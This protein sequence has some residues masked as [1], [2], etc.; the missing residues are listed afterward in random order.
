MIV[1]PPLVAEFDLAEYVG[2][3]LS[4]NQIAYLAG[5]LFLALFGLSALRHASRATGVLPAVWV[6]VAI[7]LFA[8]AL[9]LAARSFPD[10][11]PDWLRPWTETDRLTRAAAVAVL[12][13]C[14]AVLL[15]AY[16]VRGSMSRLACRMAGLGLAGVAVWLAGGWFA[17]QIP[18]PVREWTVQSAIMR[19]IVVFALVFVAAAMWV[20]QSE[21]PPHVLWRNRSFTPTAIAMAAILATRWFAIRIWPDLPKADVEFVAIVLGVIGT[22][23]CIL[24]AAGAYLLR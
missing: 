16:W 22:G 21:G 15:S 14:A 10:E 24:I 18:D 12:L 7:A 2:I 23:T 11:V 17:D 5:T 19:A 6:G 9:L 1:V 3:G 20:R 8:G 13:G 4:T